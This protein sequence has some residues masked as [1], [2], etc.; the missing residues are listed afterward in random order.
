[1][2]H[3]PSTPRPRLRLALLLASITG[4][5]ACASGGAAPA[6]ATGGPAPAGRDEPIP[7]EELRGVPG[8]DTREYPGDGVMARWLEYSPYRWVGYYLPAPCHTGTSWIGKRSTLR[9]MGWG[10]AALYV[11]E[12]DWQAAGAPALA[13]SAIAERRDCTSENLT[14]ERGR[15]H[16][17][18]AAATAAREGF[19][20]GSTLFLDVER[21]DTVS[22]PLSDYVRAWVAGMLDDGRYQPGLYAHARNA[23]ELMR[24]YRREWRERGRPDAPRLW[25]AA[26]ERFDVRAAPGESGFADAHVW[27]GRFNTTERWG[28]VSLPIDVNVA[29]TPSPSD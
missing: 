1:M 11:G 18:D 26:S 23:E 13:D 8:F 12:Q 17:A 5:T 19:P 10:L 24:I 3:T 27:Q 7:S 15:A 28:E 6:P 21:V 22:A 9:S 20:S 4:L 16:A 14:A 25:V 2:T 29:R